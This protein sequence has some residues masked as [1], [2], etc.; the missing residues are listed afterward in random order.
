[1]VLVRFRYLTLGREDKGVVREYIMKVSDYSRAQVSRLIGEYKAWGHLQ[2]VEYRRHRFP[3]K[4]SP[5]DMALLART[6]ELHGYLIPTCRDKRVLEREY[7]VYGHL[8]FRN[9]S[10]ISVAHLYNV[11]QRNLRL[12]LGRT[13]DDFEANRIWKCSQYAS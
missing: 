12:G 2:R 6:D 1:M 9:I 10:G 7:Q 13:S 11:R 4:Y 5:G 8:E 3:V